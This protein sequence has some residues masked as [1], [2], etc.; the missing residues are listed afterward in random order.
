V[1]CEEADDMPDRVAPRRGIATDEMRRHNLRAVLD[2]IHLG[3]PA[4][5]SELARITGLNR[6][7]IRDLVAELVELGVVTEG[8]GSTSGGRGRPSAVASA[9]PLGAVVVAAEL[10]VDFTSVATIGLGGH[11]FERV[12]AP[13]QT[14]S[15]SP[16]QVLETLTALAIPMMERLP[17]DRRLVGVG[18]AA[19]GL[20]RRRDSSISSSP[21][22]GWT[23]VPLGEMVAARL[24][25]GRVRVAN[26]ADAGALAEFRRGAAR[27]AS[28]AVYVSGEVGLGVGVI[29]DG[30]PMAGESGFAGEMGHTVINPAGRTCRCGSTGCW[31]TE[32]GEEA[33]ARRAGFAWGAGRQHL[34]AEVL[35]RAHAG[36]RE[37]LD[38]LR[39]V[40]RWL[41]LGVG[42]LVNIFNP[43]VIVFGGFYHPIFPFLE[44]WIVDAGSTAALAAPWRACA[45]RRS[46]LGSDSRLVGAAEI[47]FA[48]V[49]SDPSAIDADRPAR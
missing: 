23:D 26:E 20:V 29:V 48:D 19:A 2:R 40:G 15:T 33:L 21:N 14:A 10:E 5:R 39:E 42:N 37:V 31:E 13:N 4:T 7:T 45:I 16:E 9:R 6:S 11:I 46:E 38:A 35:R 43:E 27:D 25:I 30:R 41:G 12:V 24:E 49:L 3:G 17:R 22:R 47:V 18:V 8:S 28:N 44:P 1:F 32:V 36:D 34:A